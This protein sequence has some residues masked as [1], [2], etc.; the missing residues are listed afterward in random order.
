MKTVFRLAAAFAAGAAVMYFMDPVAGRRRRA[1]RRDQGVAARH[2]VENLVRAKSRRVM[3]QLQGTA[4]R[5]RARLSHS[6]LDDELLLARIH[7]R[8]G[9]LLEHPRA[10]EVAVLD[11]NVVLTGRAT[12]AEIEHLNDAVARMRGVAEVDNRL[13]VVRAT[14]AARSERELRH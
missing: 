11:G 12:A 4:A 7:S 8:L 5:A 9:H 14:P 10:V 2:Q 1:L 3:H 6:P 13:W